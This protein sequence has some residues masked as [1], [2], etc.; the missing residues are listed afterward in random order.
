MAGDFIDAFGQGWSNAQRAAD[1]YRHNVAMNALAK[2]YGP[3]SGD[4]QAAMANQQYKQATEMDPLLIQQQ[5]AVN[6]GLQDKNNYLAQAYPK[7]LVQADLAN[8]NQTLQNTGQGLSNTQNQ[9]K[10]DSNSIEL[11]QSRAQQQRAGLQTLVTGLGTSLDQGADPGAAFDAAVPQIEKLTGAPLDPAMA[12]DM[13]QKFLADPKGE[14]A[15]I[16]SQLDAA[17]TGT[18]TPLDKAKVTTETTKADLN[19]ARIGQAQAGTALTNAK[20]VTEQNKANGKPGQLDA[21]LQA[22]QFMNQRVS[23]LVDPSPSADGKTQNPGVFQQMYGLLPKMS[24][25]AA[26]RMINAH[27]P[28]TPEYQFM[29]YA[30][31]ASHNFSLDDLR[32][33]KDSG[34]SLGRTTNTEFI[35]SAKA[36]GNLSLG[37]DIGAL[38]GQLDNTFGI[39]RNLAD[40]GKQQ[41]QALQ[42][43]KNAA[44]QAPVAGTSPPGVGAAP[45]TGAGPSSPSPAPGQQSNAM[46][47]MNTPVGQVVEQAANKYGVPPQNLLTIAALESGLNPRAT[48]PRSSAAGLMQQTDSN[49]AQYGVANKLDAA[50]SAD[51]GAKFA[52]ANT[53]TFMNKFGRVPDVGELYLMHQQGPGGAL[54][55]LSNPN[56]RAADIVG[57]K[58]VADNGGDPNMTAGQFANMWMQKARAKQA[59]LSGGQAPAAAYAPISGGVA[60]YS[61]AP[62]QTGTPLM[63]QIPQGAESVQPTQP[64]QQQQQAPAAQQQQAAAPRPAVQTVVDG[65]AFQ[66][67]E[68]PKQQ[69]HENVLSEKDLLAKYGIK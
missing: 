22:A 41:L 23:Q 61:G 19:N 46:P 5:Q 39:Y 8:E 21:Q 38:K 62:Q 59:E 28:G 56:A 32:M 7:Q 1:D 18:L 20:T 51:G 47:A 42:A 25:S 54:K 15:Q 26:V 50:Q 37:Q 45:G 58:A 55:L 11:A 64:Q 52:A 17:A 44:G 13:R 65:K 66:P 43:R 60:Q 16:Q 24:Q 69:K 27:I 35:A 10:I 67:P 30:D 34:L 33:L 53:K 49:A 57:T 31:Q 36:L 9:Q 63:P 3:V 48:N 12:A 68:Q 6:T 40:A 4:P 2:I 14:L 29:Q